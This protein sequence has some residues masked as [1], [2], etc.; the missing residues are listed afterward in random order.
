M[1]SERI[2][3]HEHIDGYLSRIAILRSMANSVPGVTRPIDDSDEMLAILG[4]LPLDDSVW[5][6]ARQE[7]LSAEAKLITDGKQL[8]LGIVQRM[9]RSTQGLITDMEKLASS[10]KKKRQESGTP[11]DSREDKAIALL[12]EKEVTRRLASSSSSLPSSEVASGDRERRFKPRYPNYK[13]FYDE[14]YKGT[15][16]YGFSGTCRSCDMKG[17]LDRDCKSKNRQSIRPALVAES[18]S[19]PVAS[20]SPTKAGHGP[21]VVEANVAFALVTVAIYATSDSA[22]GAPSSSVSDESCLSSLSTPNPFAAL[23]GC[24]CDSVTGTADLVEAY[25]NV[26]ESPPPLLAE[27][28]SVSGAIT[29]SSVIVDT[30]ASQHTF[31]DASWFVPESLR[32]PTSSD[33]S[34]LVVGNSASVP[35]RGV[36]RVALV[37]YASMSSLEPHTV[38]LHNVLYAPDMGRN[39]VSVAQSTQRGLSFVFSS[40]VCEC[41]STSATPP[42]PVLFARRHSSGLYILSASVPPQ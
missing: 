7:I 40:D 36:G 28:L 39:L 22:H 35:I 11:M 10:P 41:F 32:D 30:G 38:L 37:V 20:V 17:H 12:V 34:S 25:G 4:A 8:T 16:S 6:K 18:Y 31:N 42:P 3:S 19:A 14:A 1:M 26:L 13:F 24:D 9:V 15:S 33:P 27:A 21:A 29:R 5:L 2:S 23:A